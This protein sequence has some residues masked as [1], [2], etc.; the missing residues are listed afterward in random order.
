VTGHPLNVGNGLPPLLDIASYARRGPARRDRLSPGQVEYIARTVHHTPEVMI[1]VLNKGGQDLKAIGRHIDYLARDGE[2]EVE[3]DEGR[4]LKGKGVEQ[5]LLDDWDL[6][7]DELRPWADLKPPWSG[8]APPKLVHKLMFSMPAGTPSQKVLTAVKNFAREEFGGK[9][10]YAMVLHTDEPHPHVHVIVKAMDYD[11]KRLNIRKA[12][13]RDW[14]KEFAR[15][16]REQ[17]VAANATTRAARGATRPHKLDGIYRA[18]MRGTS[19]HHR[20]REEAVARQ[21]ARGTFRAGRGKGR[22]LA[23]RR[24]VVHGWG[25]LSD[26]LANQGHPVLAAA[27]RIF[28]AQMPPPRTE[29]E[30]IRAQ[31]LE[32]A[33]GRGQPDRQR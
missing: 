29:K 4:H 12:T 21:L 27:A 20:Q 23:T 10:R 24:S 18:T 3:T 15:H 8:R 9:H 33:R 6:D 26:R 2:V 17:G 19:T 31:L 7:L 11:G 14:R 16:L 5:E 22:L 13:L 28:A 32:K 1:K 25:E 30:I